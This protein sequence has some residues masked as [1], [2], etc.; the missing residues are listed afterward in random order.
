MHGFIP[1]FLGVRRRRGAV[2]IGCPRGFPL[3]WLIKETKNDT[4]CDSPRSGLRPAGC[5]RWLPRPA[6]SVRQLRLLW[7]SCCGPCSGPCCGPCDGDCGPDGCCPAGRHPI[8]DKLRAAVG[9]CWR[10][11]LLRRSMVQSSCGP[12]CGRAAAP[13]AVP[14]ATAATLADP[15]GLRPLLFSPAAMA[16]A[17]SSATVV[18]ARAAAACCGACCGGPCDGWGRRT[19]R[20]L[21]RR[22]MQPLQQRLRLQRL[23]EQRLCERRLRRNDG[24]RRT[25]AMPITATPATITPATVGR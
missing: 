21:Q 10:H 7:R 16:S 5:P 17:F 3:C 19:L 25:T 22:R 13:V 6:L 23:C 18:A 8:R 9:A 1:S 11:R 4:Q 12:C 14:A 24:Y 2:S 15:C 20:L